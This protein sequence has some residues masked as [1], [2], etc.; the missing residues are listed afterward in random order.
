VTP[1]A[2]TLHALELAL[3]RRDEASIDGGYAAVLDPAFVEIGQRGRWWTR[4]ETLAVM[5]AGPTEALRIEGFDA[6][7]LGDGVTLVTYDLELVSSVGI[8]TWSRRSS[9]WLRRGG[10]WQLRFHQ[11]TP[12]PE[13][14]E[15][16]GGP[17]RAGG[18]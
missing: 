18:D 6:V 12:I 16:P 14:A 17:P 15:G 13:S 4:A 10:R 8:R 1:D 9:V 2:E 3:A 5:A 7:A 11:G